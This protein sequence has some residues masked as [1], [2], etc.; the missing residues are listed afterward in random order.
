MVKEHWRKF[1]DRV[2]ALALRERVMVFVMMVVILVTPINLF[3]LDPLRAKQK[4]LLKDRTA[5]QQEIDA[6]Q[7]QLM[8]AASK[9]QIDPDAEN[10]KRLRELK[11]K[12]EELEAPVETAQQ[13][14]VSP[15]KRAFLLGE[16]LAQNPR[17]R[18]VSMKTLPATTALE[19]KADPTKKGSVSTSLVYR[20]GVQMTVEGNYHD[21]LQYLE[22]L[23]KL[24]WR[25][26]WS[27]ANLKVE[28]YPRITLS[29]TLY[30]LSLE[31]TWLSI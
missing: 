28:E 25:M 18:L 20:H 15:E 6:L 19:N 5:R 30:T 11:R 1:A 7:A 27:A 16:L 21:L 9:V 26:V 12:I 4:S 13:S 23:E 10:R 2:D 3:L 14:L 29:L 17:L 24:P 22:T 8:G 31:K